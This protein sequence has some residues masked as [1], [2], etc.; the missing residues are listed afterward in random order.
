MKLCGLWKKRSLGLLGRFWKHGH[1]DRRILLLLSLED[2]L[3][4]ESKRHL[5]LLISGYSLVFVN[6][7]G[8]KPKLYKQRSLNAISNSFS[9]ILYTTHLSYNLIVS[10]LPNRDYKDH[11]INIYVR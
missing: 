3:S 7:I 5:S 8:Q 4:S 2:M 10:R 11:C 6:G 1:N 9:P